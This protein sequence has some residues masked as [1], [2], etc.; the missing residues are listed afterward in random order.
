MHTWILLRGLT[1]ESR[2]WGDFVG[3]FQQALPDH[4][5]VTLDLAGNGLL[6]QQSSPVRV[7]QMVAACRMQLAQRQIQPPCHLLAMSLGAMV[8]VAWAQSHPHEI[9]AL[10]LINTSMRP[11]SPFYQR[12]LPANYG[13]LLSLMLSG[14]APQAWERAIL[15][16]TSN[17]GEESVLPDWLAWRQANPVSR[18]NALRQLL[19]AARFRAAPHPPLAP[20]LLLASLQD[21]L[22][23]LRCSTALARHWSCSLRMHPTAGHD[24]PLDDGPWVVAQVQEWLSQRSG[25]QPL[26][27]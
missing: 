4:R 22:V 16:M 8:A 27:G 1:R 15:R 9:S 25:D 11:W 18:L 3:Q 5:V 2:H 10:V 20:T 7:Q 26:G 21:H 17:R 12:L 19:A 13:R 6:N 23:S 14:A 24:I